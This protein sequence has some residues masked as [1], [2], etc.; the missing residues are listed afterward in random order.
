M[1]DNLRNEFK[2]KTAFLE[3]VLDDL[4]VGV[5][6]LD[7]DCRVVLMN[8]KQEKLSKI[9]RQKVLGSV[10]HETWSKN[11]SKHSPSNQTFA[12]SYWNLIKKK[13]PYVFVY[14]DFI[15][16]YYD[17]K[18]SGVSYGTPMLSG[19]GFILIID[20]SEEIK[21][22]KLFLKK[23]NLQLSK[24]TAFLENL[25]D[26]SPNAVITTDKEGIIQTVNKTA[27]HLFEI[28]YKKFLLRPMFDLFSDNQI[29]EEF[30]KAVTIKEGIEV[31]CR[32]S[33]GKLFSARMQ[34]NNFKGLDETSPSKLFIFRDITLEKSL[35][36]SIAER[37]NFEEMISKL[38]SNFIHLPTKMIDH[39]IEEGLKIIGDFL[40]IDVSGLAQF[41]NDG[42]S[43]EI[44]HSSSSLESQ[45]LSGPVLNGKYPWYS[46]KIQN[47]ETIILPWVL[48]DLPG[49]AKSERKYFSK[50][51]YK[52]HLGIPLVVGN[53]ILGFLSFS[54]IRDYRS[55]P[56]DLV[57][58]LR[59][60]AEIFTNVLTRKKSE[61][62]LNK[63]F[64]EIRSLKN[65]IE[66]ERNYLRDEIRLAHNFENIIGQSEALQH[67]LFKVEQVAPTDS[68]VLVMGE[69]G[70]GKELIAR[71]IHH[72]SQ[73]KDKPLVKVNCATLAANVIESE[74]FG[75]EKGSFTGAHAKRTGRFELA[76]G[77][78]IF[79]D[80]IGELPLNLQAKLLRVVQDGEFE[81]MGGSRTIK[82][83]VRII[84]ATNRNLEQEVEK[85]RFREDLYYRLNIFPITVP[86]LRKRKEDL[87]LLINAFTK[88]FSKK[89]GKHIDNI[90][91][92]TINVWEKHSWPGNV[93]ELEN[94]IERAVINSRSSKL[95]V[96]EKFDSP[97]VESVQKKL[98]KTLAEFERDYIKA[99]LDE[100]KWVIQGKDGAAEVLGLPP[101]TL[102]SRMI[103]LDIKKP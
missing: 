95:E 81:R 26:S 43:F 28:S 17:E 99:I 102:R 61:E 25:L 34:L 21:Q 37:L 62:S 93:R 15:P 70:T 39:K 41:L 54:S 36:L 59:L 79:L 92:S 33:N 18:L 27:V 48:D 58:R 64:S 50:E 101:S 67:V 19:E 12:N 51:G 57:K 98:N 97:R 22:D 76:D 47:G 66:L 85:G 82:V 87:P 29:V 1:N 74:F 31:K 73:R 83:D 65:K 9:K 23:L 90:P 56:E 11:F 52:S 103:K 7:S 40:E 69:T 13:K 30:E 44:T 84:A 24:S 77:A 89:I 49:E 16:Q 75:H 71:A 68:I 72:T 88:K 46:K 94:V 5:M 10:F 91:Q 86:P 14:H 32:K 6:V 55:W 20:T 2:E 53:N 63:A 35:A 4:P 8:R 78:T 60:V 96:P 38:S 80:E 3:N 45:L 42:N 100:K